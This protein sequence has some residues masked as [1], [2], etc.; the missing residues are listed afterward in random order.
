V[1]NLFADDYETRTREVFE[2]VDQTATTLA[3]T[4]RFYGARLEFKF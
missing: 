1:S 3:R 4:Y 2:G